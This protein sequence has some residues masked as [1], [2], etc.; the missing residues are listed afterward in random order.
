MLFFIHAVTAQVF[1]YIY[2]IAVQLNAEWELGQ[3]VVI[4]AIA[5]NALPLR[6]FAPVFIHFEQTVLEH[7]KF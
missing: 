4:H 5:G 1:G 2:F 6:L 7:F 3:I